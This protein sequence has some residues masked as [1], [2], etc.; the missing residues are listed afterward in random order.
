MTGAA[1]DFL[2]KKGELQTTRFDE[3]PAAPL[4]P[5]EARLKVEEFAFTANNITYAV[6]GD[7]MKYWNFY[8]APE[9]WGRIPVW[10][11]AT[12]A[13]SK[14]DGV[15]VGDRV[16]GYL[17]MSTYFVI[18]AG[19]VG[20]KSVADLSPWRAEMSPVYSRYAFAKADP[21][22]D[23]NREGEFSLLS[24]LF[25]TGWLIA[26]Y[27]QDNSFAGARRVAVA[28]ASSKTAL[29]LGHALK[30]MGQDVEVIGL[31]SPGNLAFTHK[32]GCYD[33]VLTY[34]DV[35]ALSGGAPSVFVDM[36]GD[37]RVRHAAHSALGAGLK[38]SVMVGAT[39]WS[40]APANA[41]PLPGPQ[42]QFFFAPTQIEKRYGDWSPDGYQ[43][44]L[45]EAWGSF[46]QST[47]K[48]LKV[49]R[50][51]GRDGLLAVYDQVLNNKANPE[52]GHI[53]GW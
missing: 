9:G 50:T 19:K 40:A 51:K 11:Y 26:D 37:A 5:G 14:A 39:H 6:F 33:R 16:F 15:A 21:T 17:P 7:A 20:P 23:A 1:I 4:N 13:E 27:L 29:C 42:P 31:T 25:Q 10:G 30:Q 47:D 36:A 8:P 53:V 38:M 41:E 46:L 35:H 48:W 44:R 24:V 18:Q 32:T 52:E 34:A 43:K 45:N 3:H 12:V 2:V 49:R 28:S 22:Y